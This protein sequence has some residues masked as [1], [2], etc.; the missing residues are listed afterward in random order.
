MSMRA[1]KSNKKGKSKSKRKTK[2]V[3]RSYNNNSSEEVRAAYKEYLNTM[4][5]N[6][7]N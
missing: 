1:T 3:S 7:N 6:N 2:K 5:R 4:P